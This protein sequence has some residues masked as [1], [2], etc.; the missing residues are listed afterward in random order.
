MDF[1]LNTAGFPV[2]IFALIGL[3]IYVFFRF[4][5][6]YT[7]SAGITIK[8]KQFLQRNLPL[9]EILT[10]IVYL[11]W[12][13][14]F[15]IFRND[16]FAGALVI[17]FIFAL[18]W[19]SRYALKNLI[20]GFVFRSSA[21]FYIDDFIDT[22]KINGKI[23]NIGY[24]YLELESQSGSTLQIPYSEL[25][26]K[27]RIKKANRELST[28]YSF[29]LKLSPKADIQQ[30]SK[31]IEQIIINSPYTALN[32]WPKIEISEKN[33]DKQV[34]QITIFAL[35]SKYQH[36]VKAELEEMVG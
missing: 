9:F 16:I 27:T 25:V 14:D 8:R 24:L 4:T 20:A 3:L 13:V 28:G 30:L 18:Y 17:V 33:S 1:N 7:L 31:K 12:S 11:A 32:K 26:D 19:I 15:F 5:Q 35:N 2:L 10:W 23:T 34:L 29:E 6:K 21:G 36:L 22:E